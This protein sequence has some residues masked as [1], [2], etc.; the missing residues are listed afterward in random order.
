MAQTERK[1][2][3][4]IRLRPEEPRRFRVLLHNDD[5]TTMEFVVHVLRSV[6][7]KSEAEAETLMMAVHRQGKAVVGVYSRDIAHSKAQKARAMAK[8]AGFPLKV[9]TE[10]E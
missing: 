5:F 1:Q 6:F 8:E 4:R 7:F 2:G 3:Q 10:G 9:T